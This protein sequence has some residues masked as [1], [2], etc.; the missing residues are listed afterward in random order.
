MT[1]RAKKY[2]YDIIQSIQAINEY[3]G[4]KKDFNSFKKN[5]I[6]RRAVERE[7]EV[8]GEAVNRLLKLDEPPEIN[9]ARRI[10]E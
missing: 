2:L 8:I 4:K 3:I 1:E 9:N 5:K 6:I 10:V 7:F